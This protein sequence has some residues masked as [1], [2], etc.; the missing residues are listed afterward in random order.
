MRDLRHG[1]RG[2]AREDLS[3]RR[4]D[5]GGGVNGGPGDADSKAMSSFARTPG[6]A[7][8]T[9]GGYR[10]YEDQTRA[11]LVRGAALAAVLAG[12]AVAAGLSGPRIA[13]ALAIGAALYGPVQAWNELRKL[14]EGLPTAGT[15]PLPLVEPPPEGPAG[16]WRLSARE[17]ALSALIGLAV[18]ITIWDFVDRPDHWLAIFLGFAMGGMVG[19]AVVL[20]WLRRRR[21]RDGMEIHVRDVEGDEETADPPRLHLVPRGR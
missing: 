15:G 8:A 17:L 16:G 13:L 5:P 6:P 9:R 21:M 20:V 7:S 3:V 11:Q 1:R 12:L 14:R 10:P 2:F 18:A 4:E 19:D